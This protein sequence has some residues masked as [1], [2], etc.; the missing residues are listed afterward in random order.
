MLLV[1]P[2]L[3]AFGLTVLE[4]EGVLMVAEAVLAPLVLLA[5]TGTRGMNQSGRAAG[6]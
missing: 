1:V 5:A 6:K 3:V 2:L 4:S